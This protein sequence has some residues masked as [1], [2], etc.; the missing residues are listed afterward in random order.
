MID[1]AVFGASGYGGQELLRY[2][3][4]HPGFRV[5]AATSERLAGTPVERAMPQ[6]EG[7]YDGLAF[8]RPDE[9][10]PD[11]EAAR[12]KLQTACPSGAE[13]G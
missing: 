3:A 10:L 9:P 2:L 6:L 1:V 5:V 4:G 13:G 12:A 11:V 7:F 8:T